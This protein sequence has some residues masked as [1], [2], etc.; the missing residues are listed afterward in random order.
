MT[1]KSI[2]LTNF[3][4]PTTSWPAPTLDMDLGENITALA[5]CAD[6]AM[7]A[8]LAYDAR[9]LLT[10][11]K[12][13]TLWQQLSV[14]KSKS[15]WAYLILYDAPTPGRMATSKAM[16]VEFLDQTSGVVETTGWHWAAYQGCLMTV[17][18]LGVTVLVVPTEADVGP[19]VGAL[20]KRDRS[21]KR[22]NPVRAIE[23]LSPAEAVLLALPGVGEALMLRL[24]QETGGS[25]AYAL[26]AL[27]DPGYKLD[28]VGVKTRLAARN[29]LGMQRDEAL[30][31]VLSA[32][33]EKEAAA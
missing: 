32:E 18:E 7:L 24:L 33:T 3:L 1:I 5:Y 8:V 31:V 9:R 22:V 6:G 25:A 26:Q 29:A 16:M 14:L 17:Q 4:P 30:Q 11:L 19:A 10:N 15:Q 13:G 28:G 27:T 12:Q 23:A 21:T 2:A 20:G